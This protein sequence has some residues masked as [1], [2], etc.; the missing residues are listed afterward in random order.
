MLFKCRGYIRYIG[1]IDSRV[2]LGM[3]CTEKACNVYIM[4]CAQIF[5]QC[6]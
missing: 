2:A 4:L 6:D 1:G 3:Q 5:I